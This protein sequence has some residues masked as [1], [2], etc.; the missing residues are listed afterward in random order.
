MRHEFSMLDERGAVKFDLYSSYIDNVFE[1]YC[2]HFLIF[3]KDYE[4]CLFVLKI[5]TIISF[6]GEKEEKQLT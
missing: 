1:D 5:I 4:I 2:C 6:Q 3:S